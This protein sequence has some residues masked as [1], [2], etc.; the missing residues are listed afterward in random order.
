MEIY[1]ISE[2]INYAIRMGYDIAP[3]RMEWVK[4]CHA[5]KILGYDEF[6]FV[7]LSN[8]HGT[9][10]PDALRKWREEKNYNRLLNA[11]TACGLIVNLAKAAGIEVKNFLQ[12]RESKPDTTKGK[13]NTPPP[14]A[15]SAPPRHMVEYI[16]PQQVEAG[17]KGVK[18]TA[19]YTWLCKEF[20]P[21]EV[22]RVL[23]AYKVGASKF[24]TSAGYCA[25]SFPYINAAG[26]CVDCKI[27]H[28]SPENGSRHSAPPIKEWQGGAMQV[29]WALALLNKN[30]HRAPWCNF[31]DHLLAARPLAPIGI[32]ESEKTALILSLTYPDKIWIAVGSKNNLNAARLE[33][34]RGRKIT[35]FPD[36]DGYNDKPRGDNKG[37]EKGWRTLATEIAAQGFDIAIDT[38][39]EK[40]DGEPKDD[41]ADIVLRFR[42]GKQRTPEPPQKQQPPTP[43]SAERAEAIAVFEDMKSRNPALAEFAEALKLEPISVEA[44]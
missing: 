16:T 11:G 8:N 9:S 24:T 23:A 34:Y 4:L 18:L 6:T 35:L 19:L 42:H 13:H 41:L 7:A 22:E 27:F 17:T 37:I 5:L 39:T 14:K 26:L 29:T 12:G 10:A 40:H 3:D 36:R 38:T 15:L 43:I 30:D 20:E 2:I 25:S 31:G 21:T 44:V 1:N 28:L 33:A 32:V